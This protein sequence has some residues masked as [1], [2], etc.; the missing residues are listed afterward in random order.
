MNWS[1]GESDSGYANEWYVEIGD[2]LFNVAYEYKGPPATN[3]LKSVSSYKS[4]FSLLDINQSFLSLMLG[5]K[6]I[7]I[8]D[9]PVPRLVYPLDVGM[10]WIAEPS[11]N[12][13]GNS[14][15]VIDIEDIQTSAGQFKCSKLETTLDFDDA[16]SYYVW[17]SSIGKVKFLYDITISM[18]DE[19][20]QEI[21]IGY[22]TE[23]QI[24][25]S[26]N[27]ITP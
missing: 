2:T 4:N 13:F 16:I 12:F 25:E 1:F 22:F 9:K 23:T 15:E 6:D 18:T 5:N 24:L 3:I 7:I 11:Y 27:V 26:Y 17:Y 21:G 19:T 8:H 20:G 10:Q 14:N